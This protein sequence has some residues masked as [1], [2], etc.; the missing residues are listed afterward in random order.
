MPKDAFTRS[1]KARVKVFP[2]ARASQQI[3]KCRKAKGQVK[4]S[5]RSH[6][7]EKMEG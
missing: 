7:L 4:K 3:A 5:A 1:V 6:I 2:S